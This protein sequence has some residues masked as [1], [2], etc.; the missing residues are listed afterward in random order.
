MA[1]ISDTHRTA[2]R[3][4]VTGLLL[5]CAIVFSN[6]LAAQSHEKTRILQALTAERQD[7]TAELEQYQSTL[8]LLQS[9]DVTPEESANPAVRKLAE[10]SMAIKARLIK[11]AEEE[12][13]LLQQQIVAA[14]ATDNRGDDPVTQAA[15]PAA[16]PQAG[17]IESKPL[18][19]RNIDYTH[20]SEAENV[21]RLHTLLEN[22]YT[23]QQESARVLPTQ[24]ELSQREQ[25]RRD[26]DA[27]AR[28]PFSV[29]KVRLNGSE[30]SMA[31]AQISRRLT[32][33]TIPESRRDIAPICMIKTRL[34]GTLVGSDNRSLKPVGKNHYV[35]RIRLQPGDTTLTINSERWQVRLPQHVSA[36]DY[37]VTL[38]RPPGG[39][40]ELHVIAVEDLLAEDQPHIPAW[41]PQELQIKTARG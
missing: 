18:R 32:D 30:G 27:L 9:D 31:L 37:L 15:A 19:T 14:R 12:V 22:Y 33:P 16:G 35:A 17:D 1:R 11:I 8:T 10:E 3:Q 4:A 39:D 24:D 34:F 29:D 13:T 5:L 23:E 7:L 20:A 28:I 36:S 40:S 6:N 25:A 21:E 26:A 2:M 38:Y 41:L